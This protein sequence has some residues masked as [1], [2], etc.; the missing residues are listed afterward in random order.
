MTD[1]ARA[2]WPQPERRERSP[3]PHGRP[4][5]RLGRHECRQIKG[6]AQVIAIPGESNGHERNFYGVNHQAA[7]STNV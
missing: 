5:G 6:Q 3:F 4:K 2:P 1:S 7:V